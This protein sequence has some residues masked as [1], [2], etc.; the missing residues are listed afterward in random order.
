[1]LAAG[2][3]ATLRG[4]DLADLPR[5]GPWLSTMYIL[6]EAADVLADTE[7]AARVYELLTPYAGIP[8]IAGLATICMGS[9]HQTL[10]VTSLT[11]GELD[12]AVHHLRLAIQDN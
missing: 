1:R 5:S 11:T 8:V 6:A 7:T 4:R 10:G 9:T 12:G 2:A 3:I